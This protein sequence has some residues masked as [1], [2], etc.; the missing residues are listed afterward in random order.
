MEL[1]DISGIAITLLVTTIVI[2]LMSSILSSFQTNME[3]EVATHL[4]V[5]PTWAGNN[6][7]MDLQATRIFSAS[8]YNN[9]TPVNQGANWSITG[10]SLIVTN[11]SPSGK[12]GAQSEWVTDK[13]NVSYSYNIGSVAYNTSTFGLTT[14]NTI[15]SYLPLLGLVSIAAIIVGIVLV[16][17]MR[18]SQ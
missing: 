9:G 10:S 8:V 17:F 4:N 2:A 14:T 18:R 6:T 3:D 11:Q 1:K 16:M 7:P 13:I 12:V 5:T 15:A